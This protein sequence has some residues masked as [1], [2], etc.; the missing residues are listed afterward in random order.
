MPSMYSQ[1]Q[2]YR[3]K[4]TSKYRGTF[5]EI[6]MC[7]LSCDELQNV[8]SWAPGGTYFVIH[9]RK[10]LERDVLP[11]YFKQPTFQIFKQKLIRRGFRKIVKGC[12]K[13][14]FY[15]EFFRADTPHSCLKTVCKNK[16]VSSPA[17]GSCDDTGASPSTFDYV[18]EFTSS[19]EE[20]RYPLRNL[21]RRPT[22]THPDPLDN[23]RRLLEQQQQKLID[24]ACKLDINN[25]KLLRLS[26]PTVAK[27]TC[28]LQCANLKQDQ[29][30]SQFNATFARLDEM[31]K[32][33][34]MRIEELSRRN[35]FV[36]GMLEGV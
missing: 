28:Q 11:K 30:E 36:A 15:H 12:D 23:V 35:H 3:K 32:T 24:L 10:I 21:T 33:I 20:E 17:S 22:F 34:S 14:A 7:M 27:A 19:E 31:N 5:P 8:I 26:F 16:S 25:G 29:W 2:L 1:H 13:G 9:D 4:G 18:Q 6:L